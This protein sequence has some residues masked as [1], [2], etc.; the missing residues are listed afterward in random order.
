MP[1]SARKK[2]LVLGGCGDKNSAGAAAMQMPPPGVE[3]V[4][5]KTETVELTDLL[6]A[7]VSAFRSAEIRQQ[8]N[9]IIT[10]RFFEEGA[11]VKK[12]Y[13]QYHGDPR[14]LHSFPTRRSSD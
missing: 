9:G 3:V 5:L 11:V 12:V 6:P 4:T 13:Y 1:S 10:K 14:D 2:K 7:R 8:V